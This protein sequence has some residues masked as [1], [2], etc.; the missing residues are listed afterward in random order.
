MFLS[1]ALSDIFTDKIKF[2][3]ISK[4]NRPI[5]AIAYYKSS[6]HTCVNILFIA[7]ASFYCKTLGYAI[8]CYFFRT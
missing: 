8:S 6:L 7:A 1:R 3:N 2:N 5:L 4:N